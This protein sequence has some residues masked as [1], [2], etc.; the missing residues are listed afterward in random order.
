ME[1]RRGD[2]KQSTSRMYIQAELR[3]KG[4]QAYSWERLQ[5]KMLSVVKGGTN[6]GNSPTWVVTKVKTSGQSWMGIINEKRKGVQELLHMR[7][8]LFEY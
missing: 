1:W 5:N 2:L 4:W 6:I 3:A 7:I 8:M